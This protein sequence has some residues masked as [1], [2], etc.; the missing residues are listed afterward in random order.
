MVERG[1]GRRRRWRADEKGRIVAES[2]EAGAIVSEVARRHDITPQQLF[3]WRK[4]ARTSHL[5]LPAQEAPMVVPAMTVTPEDVATNMAGSIVIEIG[6]VTIRAQRG[7]DLAWLRDVL[8]VVK[9]A[10]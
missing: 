9:A 7:I 1:L 5:T 3:A 10:K 2:Y 8:K 4:A 6:G